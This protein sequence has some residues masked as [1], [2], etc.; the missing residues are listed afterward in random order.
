IFPGKHRNC[1]ASKTD[2]CR[3]RWTKREKYASL[4]AVA[5]RGVS[6]VHLSLRIANFHARSCRLEEMRKSPLHKEIAIFRAA[7][8]MLEL[9]LF[10]IRIFENDHL[11]WLCGY[12][13][14]SC[15]DEL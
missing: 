4:S 10:E 2:R 6:L 11:S 13:C 15:A 8:I 7:E 12:R 5:R 14:A 1:R 3:V 9:R